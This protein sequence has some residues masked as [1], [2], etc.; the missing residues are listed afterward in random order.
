MYS[1]FLWCFLMLYELKNCNWANRNE[2]TAEIKTFL[3][4]KANKPPKIFTKLGEINNKSFGIRFWKIDMMRW[5]FE[6]MWQHFD[7]MW[8]H[9]TSQRSGNRVTRK[10]FQERKLNSHGFY[11]RRRIRWLYKLI[12]VKFK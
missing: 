8:C 9:M 2:K 1:I 10:S 12:K 3:V 5:H 4:S 7:I 11:D 6:V